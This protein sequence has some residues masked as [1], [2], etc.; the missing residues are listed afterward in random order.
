MLSCIF[1]TAL[2]SLFVLRQDLRESVTAQNRDL[3]Q[4]RQA[5]R[6]TP[7]LHK[8]MLTDADQRQCKKDA[9]S[10]TAL[11]TEGRRTQL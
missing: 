10:L 9:A 8:L 11:M 1:G 3:W 6:V 2:A 7:T 4:V 5:I